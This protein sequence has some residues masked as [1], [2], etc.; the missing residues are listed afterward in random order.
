MTQKKQQILLFLLFLLG[1]TWNIFCLLQIIPLDFAVFS[2]AIAL[3]ANI[4]NIT[5]ACRT[6]SQESQKD[7][8]ALPRP[9]FA[10]LLCPSIAWVITYISC[11]VY[12]L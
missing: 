5:V 1:T 8:N 11:I 9:T 12:S 7:K 10:A 4:L 6:T 3:L 2:I